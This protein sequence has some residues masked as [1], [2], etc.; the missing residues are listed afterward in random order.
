MKEAAFIYTI[1]SIAWIMSLM[2]S[3]HTL[4]L[5]GNLAGKTGV[6]LPVGLAAALGVSIVNAA[7]LDRVGGGGTAPY[8][9]AAGYRKAFGAIPTIV[10]ALSGRAITAA[11]AATVFL[12]TSG[13]VFNEVFA[14]WFPNFGFAFGLLGAILLIHLLGPR[15]AEVLHIL[16]VGVAV[17]GLALLVG[18]GLAAPTP[19]IDDSSAALVSLQVRPTVSILLLFMGFD[20]GALCQRWPATTTRRHL[21]AAIIGLSVA[22]I[23]FSLWGM[24][25]IKFVTLERLAD[26]TIAHILIAK[27]VWG[28]TG[29]Y[30]IGIVVIAGTCAA[31]N[32]LFMGVSQTIRDLVHWRLLPAFG[33]IMIRPAGTAVALSLVIASMMAIGLAGTDEIDVYLQGGLL[34][35]ML[36]YVAMHVAAF[37]R[38]G[39]NRMT[40]YAMPTLGAAVMSLSALV[41]FITNPERSVLL[42]F[43]GASVLVTAILAWGGHYYLKLKQ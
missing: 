10:M 25:A 35:W 29:R 43:T 19:G 18:V 28:Q 36:N 21:I 31:V 24:V 8:S 33:G 3:P 13:F 17:I 9:E 37:G 39:P 7:T 12:V 20:L 26:T 38:S 22:A 14:Y 42:K 2:L 27:K 4:S 11:T 5:L 41:L 15:V 30:L 34:L 40:R 1:S 23:L 16:F 6:L 32:G